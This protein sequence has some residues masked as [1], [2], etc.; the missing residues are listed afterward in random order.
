MPN[1]FL[2]Y[3]LYMKRGNNA[4]KCG[5]CT[6]RIVAKVWRRDYMKVFGVFTFKDYVC[7]PCKVKLQKKY[8]SLDAAKES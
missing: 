8:V 3:Q 5:E 4:V 2:R 6:K 7:D 1:E